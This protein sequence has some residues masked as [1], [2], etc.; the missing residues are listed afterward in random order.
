MA[1]VK[2]SQPAQVV[3]VLIRSFHNPINRVI[4]N[5]FVH[6]LGLAVKINRVDRCKAAEPITDSV[7]IT[8]PDENSNPRLNDR[9]KF[10]E[11]RSV[12]YWK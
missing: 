6:E 7:S 12:I 4:L 1:R 9:G 3:H 5:S 8:G 11:E 2:N 10:W